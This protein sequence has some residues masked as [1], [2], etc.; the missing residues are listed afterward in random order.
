[1]LVGGIGYNKLNQN[2]TADAVSTSHAML[3]DITSTITSLNS[4]VIDTHQ[5]LLRIMKKKVK[6]SKEVHDTNL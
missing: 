3:R 6:F 4:P 1:M 2:M 5:E